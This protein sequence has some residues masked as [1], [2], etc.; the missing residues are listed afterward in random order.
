MRVRRGEGSVTR[1]R[2]SGIRK[3]RSL[4]RR[5]SRVF[6]TNVADGARNPCVALNFRFRR[7]KATE[8]SGAGQSRHTGVSVPCTAG[9]QRRCS[10][11]RWAAPST[12][13]PRAKVLTRSEA[14]N[15][16]PRV[17]AA[18]GDRSGA[19]RA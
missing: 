2:A 11:R 9:W 1:T 16:L 14:R 7:T 8:R 10:I 19:R 4:D 18:G 13:G 5:R 6:S 3:G 12:D 17:A 15:Q